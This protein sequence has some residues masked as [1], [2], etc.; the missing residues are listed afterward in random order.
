MWAK[1]KFVVFVGPLIL[2]A[3][4]AIIGAA[5]T[6]VDVFWGTDW[7]NRFA[8]VVAIWFS[9]AGVVCFLDG[10]DR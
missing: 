7:Q 5:A 1:I 6:L 4:V 2:L 8:L 10:G 9:L 3:V